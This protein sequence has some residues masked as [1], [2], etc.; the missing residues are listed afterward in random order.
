MSPTIEWILM[1]MS[2]KVRLRHQLPEIDMT[3]NLQIQN[4]PCIVLLFFMVVDTLMQWQDSLLMKAP[5]LLSG[6]AACAVWHFY[7]SAFSRDTFPTLQV[8]GSFHWC[9]INW[10]VAAL[11]FF[12]SSHGTTL[13]RRASNRGV[14]EVRRGVNCGKKCSLLPGSRMCR[15]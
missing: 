8:S 7:V 9:V 15:S 12:F 14:C 5:V 6:Q 4:Y 3:P 13:A 10:G 11:C 1:L 2:H